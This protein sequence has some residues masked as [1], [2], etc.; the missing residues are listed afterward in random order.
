[1]GLFAGLAGFLA[2]G[3][4]ANKENPAVV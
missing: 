3:C 4:G 1:M 2:V